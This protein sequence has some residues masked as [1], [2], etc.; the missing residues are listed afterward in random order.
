[1]STHSSTGLT[2]F[3]VIYSKPLSFVLGYILG[4]SRNEVVDSILMIRAILH[5]AL[6]H[7]LLKAQENMKRLADAKHHDDNFKVGQW[8]YVA[9]TAKLPHRV[10]HI[11]S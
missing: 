6:K 8:D 7:F 4:S 9:L 3:K 1:M 11:T 2:P 5:N 10:L